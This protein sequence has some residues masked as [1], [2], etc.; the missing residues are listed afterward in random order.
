MGGESWE[1][2]R[3]SVG[4]KAIAAR[5]ASVIASSRRCA[6]MTVGQDATSTKRLENYASE[7]PLLLLP[8]QVLREIIS[9]K[10]PGSLE[11]TVG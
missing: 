4:E 10:E 5:G 8:T 3:R 1:G 6:V 11:V 7:T 2:V 9:N